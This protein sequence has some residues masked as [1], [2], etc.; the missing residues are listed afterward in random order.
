MYTKNIS[1]PKL[2]TDFFQGTEITKVNLASSNKVIF[3]H[4]TINQTIQQEHGVASIRNK[5][6]FSSQ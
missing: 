4:V 6:K 2:Y 3:N 1:Q 5:I